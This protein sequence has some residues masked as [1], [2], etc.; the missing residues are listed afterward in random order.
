MIMGLV[1]FWKAC[2]LKELMTFLWERQTY[3]FLYRNL[4]LT[5]VHHLAALSRL[6]PNTFNEKLCEQLFAHLKKWLETAIHKHAN[7]S[8]TGQQGEGDVSRELELCA[9]ILEI[10]HLIPLAPQVMI[11]ITLNLI[12]FAKTVRFGKIFSF[13]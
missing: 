9:A 3:L 12:L 2:Y 6:F 7:S 5:V 10:F 11:F 13:L 1:L 4:T 8:T